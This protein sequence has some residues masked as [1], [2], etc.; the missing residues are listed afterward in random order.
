MKIKK[1]KL[2]II[3]TV[4]LV[5]AISSIGYLMW[6]NSETNQR[7]PKPKSK[8]ETSFLLNEIYYDC[9]QPIE[10]EWVEA[11]IGP[12]SVPGYYFQ[13]NDQE[14]F[15]KYCRS[16]AVIEYR[17]VIDILRREDV[18]N[19]IGKYST[20]EAWVKALGHK[21]IHDKA[22]L[23]RIL[24]SYSGMKIDCII[25]VHSPEG[26]RFFIED[27]EKHDSH[28]DHH[29]IE[30]PADKF[31]ASLNNAPDSDVTAFWLALH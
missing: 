16:G 26:T 22:Y 3:L 28:D 14:E 23:K 9:S 31:L 1:K 10:G 5:V 24:P 18:K 12:M 30:V 20:T 17:A 25:V 4:I 19:I 29:Y 27:G 11:G 21:Y 2:V 7:G 15:K 8:S 6:N 13:P